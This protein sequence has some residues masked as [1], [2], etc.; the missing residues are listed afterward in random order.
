MELRATWP[1]ENTAIT[2]PE[3]LWRSETLLEPRSVPQGRSEGSSPRLVPQGRLKE[4]LEPPFGATGALRG[5][6]QAL[7]GV[8]GALRGVV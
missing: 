6:V 1:L 5:A 2:A 4:L 3:P 8:T 7:L